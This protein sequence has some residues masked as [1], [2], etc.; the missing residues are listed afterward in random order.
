LIGGVTIFG[1]GSRVDLDCFVIFDSLTFIRCSFLMCSAHAL[2]E[3]G[4]GFSFLVFG[5]MSNACLQNGHRYVRRPS[6]LLRAATIF[7]TRMASAMLLTSPCSAS[8]SVSLNCLTSELLAPRT[9]GT[10]R[11]LESR[12]IGSIGPAC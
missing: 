11:V 4:P 7:S 6:F 9:S 10:A 1:R 3:A 2:N 5:A 12:T 8:G